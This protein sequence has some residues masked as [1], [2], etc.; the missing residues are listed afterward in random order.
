MSTQTYIL[1]M[2]KRRYEQK[3]FD[4]MYIKLDKIFLLIHP[5]A[6]IIIP[7]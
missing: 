3:Q 5:E 6:K 1:K 4:D 2:M 7:H